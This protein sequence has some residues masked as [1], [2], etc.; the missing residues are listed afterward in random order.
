[1]LRHDAKRGAAQ[2]LAGHSLD[3]ATVKTKLFA[4]GAKGPHQIAARIVEVITGRG[5]LV[6]ASDTVDGDT[7]NILQ[8]NEETVA[9]LAG[10]MRR[11]EELVESSMV[12]VLHDWELYRAEKARQTL[13]RRTLRRIGISPPQHRCSPPFDPLMASAYRR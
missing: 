4:P 2:L 6:V 13:S 12:L 11:V 9:A 5:G 10:A 1:L 8:G 7:V 3:V